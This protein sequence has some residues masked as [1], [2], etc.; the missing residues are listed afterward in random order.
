MGIQLAEGRDFSPGNPADNMSS[1]IVN[2][3]FVELIWMEKWE[4][5]RNYRGG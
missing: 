3:A 1:M 4:W 2:E 5:A